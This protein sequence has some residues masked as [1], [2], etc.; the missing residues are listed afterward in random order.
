MKKLAVSVVLAGFILLASNAISDI[1]IEVKADASEIQ[2]GSRKITG[3]NG[4]AEV[5]GNEND[6]NVIAF[7]YQRGTGEVPAEWE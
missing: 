3:A 2:V 7:F 5:G 4:I 1:T 6:I